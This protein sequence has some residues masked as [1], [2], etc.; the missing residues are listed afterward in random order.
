MFA[1]SGALIGTLHSRLAEIPFVFVS[2]AGPNQ[3][4]LPAN[5]SNTKRKNSLQP[6]SPLEP[7]RRLR[8]GDCMY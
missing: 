5:S 7:L 4:L 2:L 8:K 3:L 1:L 6:F